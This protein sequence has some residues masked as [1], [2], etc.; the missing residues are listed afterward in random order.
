MCPERVLSAKNRAASTMWQR[1]KISD[2]N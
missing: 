2:E 1:Q